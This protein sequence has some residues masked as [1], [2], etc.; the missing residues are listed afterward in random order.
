MTFFFF[1][2]NKFVNDA[3]YINLNLPNLHNT[4]GSEKLDQPNLICTI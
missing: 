3:H 1:R 2:P 4:H